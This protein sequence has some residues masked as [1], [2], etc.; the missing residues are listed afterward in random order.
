MDWT[1]SGRSDYFFVMGDDFHD[2]TPCQFGND[3]P[4]QILTAILLTLTRI[5]D[6]SFTRNV[7]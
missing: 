7:S 6:I 5:V 4:S 2:T 3:L 1:D